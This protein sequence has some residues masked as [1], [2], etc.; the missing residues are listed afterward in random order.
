VEEQNLA[1][2]RQLRKQAQDFLDAG[3]VTRVDVL[4]AETTAKGAERRLAAARQMRENAASLLR[5]S[6]GSDVAVNVVEP[7]IALPSLPAED[8]LVARAVG[9]R[10]ELQRARIAHEIARL[11]VAKQRGAYLPTV[12][13]EA[14][15]TSQAS[16]FP[17]DEYGALTLNFNVPI[18]TSGEI[19]ARVAIA[20]EQEKQAS[21]AWEEASHV[22]REEIRRTL[23][24]LSTA[25]TDLSLAL[26]QRAA[27]E[28][29]YEQIFQLYQAQE[30][31]SLDVQA[32]E[33]SLAQA[34]RAVVTAALDRE[35][36]TLRVWFSAGGL[37]GVVLEESQ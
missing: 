6:V 1:V 23:V 36:A 16:A 30:A 34:R 28:A 11:E 27:A 24:A 31:T 13:A 20:R 19:G 26:E 33:T 18:F 25:E 37:R 14:S 3:E 7:G 35:I 21:L 9:M 10:P 12:R 8:A 4:R 5:L 15:Y 2:A 22:V 17:A 29:E 32:A